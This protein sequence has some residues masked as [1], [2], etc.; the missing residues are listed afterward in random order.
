MTRFARIA[1]S[2]VVATLLLSGIGGSPAA[3]ARP[4]G[5]VADDPAP[6]DPAPVD[7]LPD[8]P[9][10]ALQGSPRP[11]VDRLLERRLHDPRLG[12]DVAMIVLDGPTGAV[13]SAH[14]PDRPM[15]TASNMKVITAVSALAT[16]RPGRR[17]ATT[18]L[19][20]R[21]PGSIIL[22]GAGDPLLT[23]GDLQ[24]LARRTAGRIRGTPRVVVHVD[25]SLFAPNRRGPGWTAHYP[26][27]AIAPVQALAR[28]GDYGGN[29]SRRAA[30]VFASALRAH[31][32][33]ARVGGRQSATPDAR[34]L[35]RARGHTLANSVAVMLRESESNVAEVLFRHVA[36]ASGDRPTWTGARRASERALTALG[37]DL[38][39]QLIYDGSGLSR[40]DRLTPR[41]L[42]TVL[43]IVRI[44][45]PERFTAIF[46]RKAM[47]VAG[48]TGTLTQRYGR[49]STYPSQCARGDVQAKTGTL[50]DTIALSGIARTVS[51]GRRVFSILVNDRPMRYTPLSTRRAVDGLA[52][53]I[54]GCWR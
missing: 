32:V 35:V 44:T 13:V 2:A 19:R 53:T 34:V 6:V 38:A 20:G 24:S 48:R 22:Q 33:P 7:L 11:R 46:A 23:T 25:G 5:V 40:K 52:A 18:V 17:F 21:T 42:A 47:P 4:A 15:H 3:W 30:E 12:D 45:Q 50:F 28:R 8:S 41:F 14:E 16:M 29:P 9:S 37:A 27:Y 26:S 51:G 36:V 39:G 10:P 1:G 43:R 49:Y 31:G 54:T